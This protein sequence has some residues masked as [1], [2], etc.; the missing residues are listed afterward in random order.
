MRLRSDAEVITELCSCLALGNRKRL[1]LEC[2]LYEVVL[3]PSVASYYFLSD[4]HSLAMEGG[5]RF[6]EILEQGFKALSESELELLAKSSAT[7]LVL[8]EMV[9]EELQLVSTAE[10][11]RKNL[12]KFAS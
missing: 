5:L 8:S 4:T 9:A 12:M 11:W 10:V 2:I 7:L 1:D 3:R 6:E